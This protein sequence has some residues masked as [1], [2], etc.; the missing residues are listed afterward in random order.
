MNRL[1]LRD[2]ED[3]CPC[4]ACW[5]AARD[6]EAPLTFGPLPSTAQPVRHTPRYQRMVQEGHGHPH[7]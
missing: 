7:D 5:R 2:H 6:R 4:L 1:D 3:D